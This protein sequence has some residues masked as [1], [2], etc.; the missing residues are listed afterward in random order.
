MKWILIGHRGVG[1]TSLLKRM[2]SYFS[3]EAGLKFFDLDLEISKQFGKP[4]AQ[5]F[6]DLGEEAFRIAEQKIFHQIVDHHSKF[7][8]SV[9]A[10]FQ[11]K[12]WPSQSQ[13]LWVRRKTD[14]LGRIF[15]N[16]PRLNQET[17]PLEEY[18]ERYSLRQQYYQAHS[19]FQ[20]WM[21]EGVEQSHPVEEQTL[22]HLLGLE[23]GPLKGILTLTSDHLKEDIFSVIKHWQ[24]DHF[25]LRDDL[26]S[27]EQILDLAR[28]VP[29]EKILLSF[30][31]SIS[32]PELIRLSQ[33]VK[34]DWALELGECFFG[35][36]LIL[37]CHTSLGD[38][39]TSSPSHLKFSPLIENFDELKTCMDWQAQDASKRSFL[40]RSK[41]GKWA[42]FRLWM[43]GRQEI[44][45]VR[46]DE[47]SSIDQPSLYE[48]IS[49][50][51][52][53]NHFAAILGHPVFHS[54]TPQ[55]QMDY[56][57][58]RH[59]PVLAIDIQE[60][61]F[62]K[63]FS[64]L[65]EM[66]LEAA[67]V[68][69]PLK[70]EAALISKNKS[71]KVSE[72]LSAN[73][74]VKKTDEEWALENTD[75]EGLMET[76]KDLNP[77]SKVA[78]WGGGGT[79]SLLKKLFPQA[80]C[81]SA[82]TGQGREGGSEEKKEQ[83]L[84]GPE[85]LIWAASPDSQPPEKDWKPRIVVDLNYREDSLAREYALEVN[86]QYRDGLQMFKV[87]AEKQREFWDKNLK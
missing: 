83:A 15:F 80:V 16:R 81:Y 42:W 87:Q 79:L 47:G 53:S 13:V 85:V 72:F 35:K 23:I 9:G 3:S 64:L 62:S 17:T 60:Q 30:R 44:N 70:K 14:S 45:F 77:F 24:V 76:F 48:W 1:K 21:P 10:G 49:Q 56:F 29:K 25:E 51:T 36:P 5:V 57:H 39:P 73:T 46:I 78:I 61:E 11:T 86:A 19:H 22:R 71:S 52:A 75:W 54:R 59:M 84:E 50:P 67:A 41:E 43:K 66:G 2:E 65:Q 20:Y 27:V 32:A 28:Q 37:S 38:L 82:R 58:Q 4:V 18:L 6:T 12:Q 33:S 8:I 31:K 26:L 40:P 69:A 7:I 55:E 63:A 68:T 74:M 34:W